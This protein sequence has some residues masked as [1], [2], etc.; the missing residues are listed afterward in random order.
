[1]K[2]QIFDAKEVEEAKPTRLKLEHTT[3]R[4]IKVVAVDE[5]GNQRLSGNILTFTEGGE[6]ILHRS[7]NAELGFQLDDAGRVKLHSEY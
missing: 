1:M 3:W 5:R 4:G 6:I 7:V 2:L